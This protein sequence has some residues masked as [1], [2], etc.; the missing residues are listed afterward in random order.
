MHKELIQFLSKHRLTSQFILN[1]LT[2]PGD[3][4]LALAESRLVIN[5]KDGEI[6]FVAF[7]SKTGRLHLQGEFDSRFISEL[8][9][10]DFTSKNYIGINGPSSLM[11]P[12]E[13][14]LKANHLPEPS[15]IFRDT[16]LT[17]PLSEFS[18]LR[19]SDAQRARQLSQ[20]DFSSWHSLYVAY[21]K[22]MGISASATTEQ[23][24][25]RFND[26][27]ARKMHWGVEVNGSLAAIV[28]F[29]SLGDTTAQ[30]GG[31]FTDPNFRRQGYSEKAM[32]TLIYDSIKVH[33]LKELILYTGANDV[34]PYHLYLKLGFKEQAEYWA[35]EFDHKK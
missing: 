32:R 7:L 23:R 20:K 3:L 34:A 8:G 22:E 33:N 25:A 35:F 19:S 21:L 13:A 18:L 9:K 31:V 2:T 29:N 12:L 4:S 30:V 26:E 27:V 10:F 5:S 1:S 28:A 24:M 17:L 16:V 6:R 14:W 11:Q 15:T